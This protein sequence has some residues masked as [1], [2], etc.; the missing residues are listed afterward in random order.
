MEIAI[1]GN[2]T[3]L[4]CRETKYCRAIRR[5][6]SETGHATNAQL[7]A[8][9][10]AE[11]PQLSATTIHRATARLA[12]RGTIATAPPTQDGVMRYDTNTTPH[13]HF[14]CR[15]CGILRDAHLTE[16]ATDMLRSEIPDCEISGPLLISGI[17]S[18]CKGET[19]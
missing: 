14:S 11:Y 2:P 1:T 17:C 5:A 12:A 3:T 16:V 18:K 9:L 15:H 13:D 4:H 10:L 19:S 8:A 6:L 7:H